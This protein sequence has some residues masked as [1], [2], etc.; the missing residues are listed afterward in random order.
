MEQPSLLLIGSDH[1]GFA[2]KEKIRETLAKEFPG[3]KVKDCGCFSESSVD[4]PD[5]A[6]GVGAEVAADATRRGIL[7][8]GSG[9]GM[10][11]AANKVAGIRAAQVWDVTSARLCREHNNANIACFGARLVGPEVAMDIVRIWLKTPFQAGRHELRVQKIS[12][13]DRK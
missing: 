3:L 1:A 12:Q 13:L 2:L 11:I 8:C 5:I 9:I 7:I 4:Y 6:Q 10:T